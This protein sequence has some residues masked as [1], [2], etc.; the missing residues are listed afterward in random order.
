MTINRVTIDRKYPLIALFTDFDQEKNNETA[1][2]YCNANFH[3]IIA[4][5]TTN[6]ENNAEERL[7]Q[8]FRPILEPIYLEFM[9]QIKLSGFFICG[10][11]IPH[12]K[13]DRYYWGKNGLFGQEGNIFS[14]Y[15]DAIEITNLKLKVK[16]I[17]SDCLI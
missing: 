1:G 12:T 17:N 3:L 14:D 11:E 16:K 6:K 8:N 2:Y 15:I 10:Y 7:T 5:I 9:K 4:N 13:T